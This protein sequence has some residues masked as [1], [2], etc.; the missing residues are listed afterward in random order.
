MIGMDF[1]SFLIL[2]VIAIIVAA[3]LHCALGL[4]VVSGARSFLA[5]VVVGWIGA[6]LGSPVVG[7]WW[8]PLK[9]CEIYIVPAILGAAALLLVAVDLV[10]SLGEA[11]NRPAGGGE[12]TA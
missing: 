9:Y 11:C 5:K 4:Y 3:V 7:H 1:G 6:W 10:K 2:L 12:G 8:A